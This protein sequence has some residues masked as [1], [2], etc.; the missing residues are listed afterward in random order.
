MHAGAGKGTSPSSPGPAQVWAQ[1]VARRLAAD[2]ALVVVNDLN[3]DGARAVADE[4]GGEAAVFDVT[5][6][7]AFDAAVDKAVARHGRLDIM[8]NNAGIAPDPTPSA[9]TDGQQPD[10]AHRGPD[11]RDEAR[12]TCSSS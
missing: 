6:S 10:A 7:A 5:D 12:S 1:H 11:R 3:G 4:V 2:G 8:I 9:S